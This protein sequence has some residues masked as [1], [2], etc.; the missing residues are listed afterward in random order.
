MVGVL[1][2]AVGDGDGHLG[3][4]P[5]ALDLGHGLGVGGEAGVGVVFCGVF[6]VFFGIGEDGGRRGGQIL[7]EPA[8]HGRGRGG[9]G[10]GGG[11]RDGR[12]G[13]RDGRG[14]GLLE[15][16]G[17]RGGI[18]AARRGGR[19]D[20]LLELGTLTVRFRS[21]AAVVAA[22]VVTSDSWEGG[23]ER[24]GTLDAA[25]EGLPLG[26]ALGRRLAVG[27]P[28]GARLALGRELSEGVREG[29]A[30]TSQ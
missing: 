4:G 18:S 15:G 21:D 9:G 22:V 27:V 14:D 17:A 29:S 23:I 26:T 2:G 20:R 1:A 12:G 6:G 24:D 30:R 28:V 3:D 11:G 19:G 8:P 13:G 5:V 25:A 10:R 16:G 7:L